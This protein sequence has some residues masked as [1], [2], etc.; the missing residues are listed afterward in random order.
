MWHLE[1][2][3]VPTAV[4]SIRRTTRVTAELRYANDSTSGILRIEVRD[5]FRYLD[6]PG[7]LRF[8]GRTAA[9]GEGA[10]A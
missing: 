6:A 5:A 8:L 7:V 4:L 2:P 1:V 9:A 10:S 3:P